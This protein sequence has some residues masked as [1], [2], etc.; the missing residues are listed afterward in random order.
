VILRTVERTTPIQFIIQRFFRIFPTCLFSVAIVGVLMNLYSAYYGVAQLN[1]FKNILSSGLILNSLN[2]EF[3]TIPVLWTLEVEVIF[4]IVMAIAAACTRRIG[5]NI[6]SLISIISFLTAA[7]YASAAAKELSPQ[8]AEYLK[9]LTKIFIHIS[10]MVI[11]AVIYKAYSTDRYKVG[12]LYF[13]FS[14]AIAV[15]AFYLFAFSSH[16]EGIGTNIESSGIAL[17]VFVIAMISGMTSR[18][19]LPL[20]WIAT[21]SY[22][23]YLVHIPLGWAALYW[24]A[25]QGFD[26]NTA[27]VSSSVIVILLSWAIHHAMELPS[28]QIGKRV[29]LAF[30]PKVPALSEPI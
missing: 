20:W 7:L 3:S 11:G 24:I 19:Y 15:A 8:Y 23:L 14:V 16:N 18:I 25:S 26:I 2:G 27:A 13:V 30:M 28:Q 5:F 4:Y 10:Y 22:P 1:T 29:S 6:L 9:H 12:L 17:V 21:I